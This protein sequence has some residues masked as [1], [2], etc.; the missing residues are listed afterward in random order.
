MTGSAPRASSNDPSSI[1]AGTPDEGR[2]LGLLLE[3]VRGMAD[4]EFQRSERFDTKSRNQLTAAGSLFTVAMAATAGVLNALLPRGDTVQGWVYPSLVAT[5]LVSIVSLGVAVWWTWKVWY[6]YK[7]DALDPK[8]IEQYVPHA[9]GGNA[10]V[11]R[12]LIEAHATI[13]RDRRT[14]NGKRATALKSGSWWCLIGAV[15][16]LVQLAVVFVALLTS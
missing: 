15:A 12:K 2:Q 10:Q 5:A 7:Q 6:L 8:T 16:G 4:E 1:A 9:E 3:S 14:N 13:L 11:A